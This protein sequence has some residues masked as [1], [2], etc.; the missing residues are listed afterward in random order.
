MNDPNALYKDLVPYQL[1]LIPNSNEGLALF[2]TDL[3]LKQT[4][5]LHKHNN[6]IF[7]ANST[8]ALVIQIS[9]IF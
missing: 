4:Q 5:N 6:E 2:E 7:Q 9:S 1:N 3:D 8:L